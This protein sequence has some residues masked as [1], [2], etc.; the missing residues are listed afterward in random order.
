MEKEFSELFEKKID[1]IIKE[2]I[3]KN[4][5]KPKK[6]IIKEIS[7][8]NKLLFSKRFKNSINNK[9]NIDGNFNNIIKYD[10]L[11]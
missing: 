6:E 2:I 9:R 7:N 11:F 4:E 1:N 8:T 10:N 5:K 3:D